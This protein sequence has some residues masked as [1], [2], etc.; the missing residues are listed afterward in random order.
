MKGTPFRFLSPFSS[1][2]TRASPGI[3]HY[4]SSLLAKLNTAVRHFWTVVPNI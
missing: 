2:F 1:T 4:M 3:S